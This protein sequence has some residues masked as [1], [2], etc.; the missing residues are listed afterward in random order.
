MTDRKA[1]HRLAHKEEYNTEHKKEAILVVSFGTSHRDTAEKTIGAVERD[2]REKYPDKE[3]RRAYTSSMILKVLKKRDGIHIDNVPEALDRL[4]A[5]GFTHLIIQPTHIIPGWEYEKLLRETEPYR[6]R[7]T[8]LECSLPL[9]ASAE[10]HQEVCA[11]IADQFPRLASDEVLV[12]MGHGTSHPTDTVYAALDYRFKAIGREN[13]FIGTVEG[14]PSLK[15]VIPMV[16]RRAPKQVFL[17]PFMV[18][19]G[20]HASNDMAGDDEDSWKS[21]FTAAGFSVTPILKGLAEFPQVRAI[22]LHHLEEFLSDP[23][24]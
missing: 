5:D 6:S 3:V 1:E 20:D 4:L 23:R 13:I 2:I 10:D 7:F 17:L 21:Q 22:Y 9:L 16:S 8:R 14:Y 15:E 18:V 19:A 24:L 12:L 11:A